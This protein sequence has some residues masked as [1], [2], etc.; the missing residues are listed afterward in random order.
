MVEDRG[1]AL[2]TTL[3]EDCRVFYK[4]KMVSAEKE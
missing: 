1:R 2:T 4:E 3:R